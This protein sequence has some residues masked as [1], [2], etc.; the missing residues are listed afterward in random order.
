MKSNAQDASDR[1]AY[2]YQNN[3]R[4]KSI[5]V[6]GDSVF[7]LTIEADVGFTSITHYDTVDAFGLGTPT[8]P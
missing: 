6:A 5:Y 3:T 7:L 4:I 2:F 1:N 8:G